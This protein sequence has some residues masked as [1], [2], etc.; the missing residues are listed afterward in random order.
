MVSESNI[1]KLRFCS[2]YHKALFPILMVLILVV[3]GFAVY[4][5]SI[6]GEFIL[7]D[8]SLVRNNTFIKNIRFIPDIFAND[9]FSG[10]GE[11]RESTFYRPLQVLSYMADY[12]IWRLDVRGYHITNI[13]LHIL[14]ALSIS[15]FIYLLFSDKLLALLTSVFFIIHPVHTEAVSYIS[16]RSDPLCLLFIMLSFIFCIRYMQKKR[17]LFLIFTTFCYIAALLSKESSIILPVLLLLY[18]YTFRKKPDRGLII[19]IAA[20]TVMYIVMRFMVLRDLLPKIAHS[21][22]LLE[23]IPGFFAALTNYVRIILIP[24]NL[25]MEYGDPGFSITDPFA[26]AGIFILS[27]FAFYA[28]R[29]RGNKLIFFS[30][31]WFFIALMPQSNLY[32]LNAYM[33]EHW[34][35]IPSVGF[36]LIAAGGLSHLYRDKRY[37]HIA[38]ILISAAVL[39]YSFMTIKQNSYWKDLRSFYEKTNIRAPGNAR[40]YNNLGIVYYDIGKIKEAISLYERAIKIKPQYPETYV[41][42]G[43]AYAG[44][45]DN[46]K[47]IELYSKAIELNP[48]Y[49]VAYNNL[50]IVYGSTGKDKEALKLLEKAIKLNPHYENAYYN[51][52]IM[53]LRLGIVDKAVDTYNRVIELNPSSERAYRSLGLI[54]KDTGKPKEAI[55]FFK[56]A[57]DV[58]PRHIGLYGDLGGMFI[59]IGDYKEAE[60]VLKKGLRVDAE[61]ADIHNNLAVVYYSQKMYDLAIDHCDRALEL[62]LKVNPEFLGLLKR[63]RKQ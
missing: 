23:R 44:I 3:L 41:N 32:P 35:Y 14:T 15:W 59:S 38:V 53:Y 40:L 43:K 50:A 57:I 42:L 28:Y 31:S 24:L 12:R 45:G 22:I 36:F 10:S 25:H 62:G 46:K 7:D 30:V 63:Y 9:I 27:C 52:A 49:I 5:N 20:V 61:N 13:I 60:S 54:C 47:A 33:A 19:S 1:Y 8:Y 26:I 6:N 51:L 17:F 4:A 16:G 37:K 48:D 29:K 18:H 39:S 21:R 55:Y 34:L 11:S 58:N 56:K 2:N